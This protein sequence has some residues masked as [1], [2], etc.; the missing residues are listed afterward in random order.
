MIRISSWMSRGTIGRPGLPCR[1]FHVQNSRK[2]LRCQAI[3]VAALT[4]K[5][6]LRHSLQTDESQTHSRPKCYPQSLASSLPNNAQIRTLDQDSHYD[7]LC[8][9]IES[10]RQIWL[11]PGRITKQYAVTVDLISRRRGNKATKIIIAHQ[12]P[13]HMLRAPFILTLP[14]ML[15]GVAFAQKVQTDYDKSIDFSKFH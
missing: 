2:P 1:T 11:S 14:L 5:T 12:P 9:R 13:F 15:A 6:L 7:R 8:D 3:T 10:V 4:M